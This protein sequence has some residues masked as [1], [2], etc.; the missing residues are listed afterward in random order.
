MRP[1]RLWAVEAES[2]AYTGRI[3]LRSII[4]VGSGFILL[5]VLN[6]ARSKPHWKVLFDGPKAANGEMFDV[7]A[8]GRIPRLVHE[9]LMEKLPWFADFLRETSEQGARA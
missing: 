9:G 7:V 5:P 2:R 8:M 4:A 1:Y 3:D 6:R